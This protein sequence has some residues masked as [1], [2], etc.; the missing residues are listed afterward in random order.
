[1]FYYSKMFT[2]ISVY[3][4]GVGFIVYKGSEVLHG[5][6]WKY[7]SQD[8]DGGWGGGTVLGG[9]LMTRQNTDKDL[10]VFTLTY[11]TSE[12]KTEEGESD[13]EN[14]KQVQHLMNESVRVKY[15]LL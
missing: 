5:N 7:I 13:Y 14:S 4:C 9:L 2:Y 10:T 8:S 11:H 15:I 1:M 3:R 12:N 6:T